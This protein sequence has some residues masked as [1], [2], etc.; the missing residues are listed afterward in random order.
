MSGA[1]LPPDTV[2][3]P[4]HLCPQ[5][6]FAAATGR[7]TSCE[8]T[9]Q[10]VPRDPRFRALIKARP[11]H[12]ILSADYAAIELRIAAVLAERAVSECRTNWRQ[13]RVHRVGGCRFSK[14]R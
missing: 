5:L 2:P 14:R 9:L 7:N 8:P 3:L 6:T 10:N 1:F 4:L 11:G 12:L 13:S